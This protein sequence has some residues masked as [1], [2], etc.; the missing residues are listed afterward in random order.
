MMWGIDEATNDRACGSPPGDGR[1]GDRAGES[2]WIG[3]RV[4]T[5]YG[6]VLKVDNNVV[7]DEGRTASVTSSGKDRRS[8]RVYRVEHT[9]GEW[10]WLQD[11]KSGICGW[12]Q[13]KYV[14]PFDQAID[15]Y[16]NQIRANPQAANYCTR[17]LVWNAKGRA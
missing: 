12:V 13:S 10:L 16:T 8:A 11:E 2:P 4:F 1:P 15:F 5:Q 9:N 7:D 3:K 6:T 14:I 17:G